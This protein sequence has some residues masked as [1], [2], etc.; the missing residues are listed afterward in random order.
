MFGPCFVTSYFVITCFTIILMG[1]RAGWFTLIL[2]MMLR[3]NQESLAQFENLIKLWVFVRCITR[4]TM[5]K[6]LYLLARTGVRK[7]CSIACGFSPIEIYFSDY[8]KSLI[9]KINEVYVFFNKISLWR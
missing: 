5:Y 1:K 7:I 6:K 2:F 9:S 4:S 3:S 8:P